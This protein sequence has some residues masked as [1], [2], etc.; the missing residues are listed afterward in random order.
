MTE[1]QLLELYNQ[2]DDIREAIIQERIEGAPASRP[3][4]AIMQRVYDA[5]GVAAVA[6]LDARDEIRYNTRGSGYH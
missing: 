4:A 2:L 6:I 5:L 3:F 1:K